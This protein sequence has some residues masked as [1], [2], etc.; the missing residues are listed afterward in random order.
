MKRY[1]FL[2]HRWLGIALCLFMAMWFFSGVVMMYMGYPKL[3][4]SER[5]EHLPG[6]DAAKC[7][8]SLDEAILASG[9]DD[10]PKGVRLTSVSSVPRYVMTFD[11]HRVVAVDAQNGKRINAVSASDAVE[12]ASAFSKGGEVTYL[13]LV[14]EDAW[15]HSKALD[16]HR[17][18]HRVQIQ[19]GDAT[20]LYVSS[21]T[22]EV[23]RD[24][25]K[26]ERAWNWVGAWVP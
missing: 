14:Q 6:L 23:V 24:A 9:M 17:P 4:A 3:T 25:T 7:C 15:T 13:D 19:D 18:L 2:T 22:G 12:A 11:K 21:L 10:S 1:L 26:T 16:L 20:L 5:L 8:I